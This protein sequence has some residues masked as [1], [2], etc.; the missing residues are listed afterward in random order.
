MTI[1][2][3]TRGYDSELLRSAAWRLVAERVIAPEAA[4]AAIETVPASA[5]VSYATLR[6]ILSALDGTIDQSEEWQLRDGLAALV[7]AEPEPRL[8]QH[9]GGI[10]ALLK[11]PAAREAIRACEVKFTP[12]RRMATVKPLPIA[13]DPR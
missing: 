13:R 10:R 1:E 8:V 2:A 3:G 7:K 4:E 11:I 6:L 5:E 9:L 12:P